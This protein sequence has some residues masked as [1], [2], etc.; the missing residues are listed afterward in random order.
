VAVVGLVYLHLVIWAPILFEWDRSN[1]YKG[2]KMKIKA[3]IEVCKMKEY[4][5]I[6]KKL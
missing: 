2:K 4:E 5:N 6:L 3:K 1:G